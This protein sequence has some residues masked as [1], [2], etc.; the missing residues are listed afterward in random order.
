MKQIVPCEDMDSGECI[1]PLSRHLSILCPPPFLRPTYC[2]LSNL[3]GILAGSASLHF[4]STYYTLY[5]LFEERELSRHGRRQRGVDNE[6]K[7][8]A[9]GAAEQSTKCT[10]IETKD[11]YSGKAEIE[12][13]LGR[14]AWRR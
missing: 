14:K 9:E 12:D 11:M 6:K 8:K 3:P 7:S 10:I 4:C 5:I 2:S 1:L 13:E